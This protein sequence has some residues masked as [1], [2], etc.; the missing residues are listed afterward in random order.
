MTSTFP[1]WRGRLR[2]HDHEVPQ[3]PPSAE[4]SPAPADDRV[5]RAREAVASLRRIVSASPIAA[6][7]GAWMLLATV[8]HGP[9][10]PLMAAG[11]DATLSQLRWWTAFTAVLVPDSVVTGTV[12]IVIG[13]PLLIFAERH[14]RPRRLL[15]ALLGGGVVVVLL[16]VFIQSGIARI[17]DFQNVAG[18]S[19]A[20]PS[21]GVICAVSAAA[22]VAPTL[23]R[24]RSRLIIGLGALAA[25]LY[26]GDL[27][28]WLSLLAFVVGTI[29]GELWAARTP[30][31]TW[32]RGSQHERRTLIAGAVAVLGIGPIAALVN[33]GGRGPLSVVL[34]AYSDFDQRI[35]A[36]C[37]SHYLPV[38]DHQNMLFV[39][40][41]LGPAL[42]AVVPLVLLVVAAIGLLAGRRSAWVL[43]IATNGVLFIAAFGSAL[44]GTVVVAGEGSQQVVEAVLWGIGALALPAA[45][46]LVLVLAR[47]VFAVRSTRAAAHRFALTVTICFAVFAVVFFLG[48]WMLRGAWNQAP[49]PGELLGDALRRFLPPGLVPLP[50]GTRFPHHGPGLFLWQWVGVVFWAF[51]VS[52]V[53]RLFSR[54]RTEQVAA[55]DPYRALVTTTDAG[56]LGWL[57]TWE[58]ARHWFSEDG[59]SAVAYRLQG[60]VAIAISDPAADDEHRE[61]AIRGFVEF[62]SAHGWTPVF[63]SVHDDTRRILE[64]LGWSSMPVAEETVLHP[65]TFTMAG[66]AGEKVRH[67]V[68]RM[69]RE[70]VLPLW[71]SWS[72]LS[73]AHARQI[74]EI[75]E[76][77]ASEKAL[78]E[79]GFTLGSVP[80]MQDPAVRLMLAVA[81]D[82]TV[83][84][85][86]SWVPVHRGGALVGWTLDVMRRAPESP[87]GVMEF[88]IAS[89]ALQMQADGAEILSLSGA[90]LVQSDEA[91]ARRGS[92]DG[93]LA[94]LS[95]ALE[96][97]YGFASLFR[98]KKKFR[99]EYA[100][101]SMVYP[102]P[103]ELPAIGYALVRTYLPTASG[104]HLVEFARGLFERRS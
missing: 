62:S 103:V 12:A 11:A 20:D 83:L 10:R 28:S 8:F 27:S 81:A 88:L 89:A 17:P 2:V 38:C 14:L 19:V 1:S 29:I 3:V 48:E 95:A 55:S 39:T 51:F 63:Y 74:R 22:G 70:G 75:S 92:I 59:S 52:A 50:G 42:L 69:R 104:R 37:A 4:T 61:E 44:A 7:F 5:Q 72:E 68:T 33:G 45:T 49:T 101:L 86:T 90:P 35:S 79:M 53:L 47:S 67:P 85:V 66:K 24:R 80:E 97:L 32:W 60:G 65:R 23:W 26:A 91:S 84:G 43:A 56:T 57:G 76:H 46:I 64:S 54:T 25:A 16:G 94:S 36:R 73:R 93:L 71:T 18:L 58:G 102:D 82:D 41:G 98:F 31:T 21:I 6:V 87:N 34:G 78:P 96:P 9:W 100:T 77:W 30:Q 15:L 13:V 99:P 40:R